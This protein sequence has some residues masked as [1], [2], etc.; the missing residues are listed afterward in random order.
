MICLSYFTHPDALPLSW[1]LIQRAET[2]ISVHPLVH[3]VVLPFSFPSIHFYVSFLF[4]WSLPKKKD[5]TNESFERPLAAHLGG[6]SFNP[7]SLIKF[8]AAKVVLDHD[9]PTYKMELINGSFPPETAIAFASP[10][11]PYPLLFLYRKLNH[12]TRHYTLFFSWPRQSILVTRRM[13]KRERM[14]MQSEV[15]EIQGSY[16]ARSRGG[17]Q[18]DRIQGS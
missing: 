2:P 1:S 12:R 10:A 4:I 14:L 6:F 18:R 17:L 3:L 11:T 16:V 5:A 8:S 13:Q 7:I 15:I 9:S